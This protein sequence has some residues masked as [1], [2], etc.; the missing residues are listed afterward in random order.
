MLPP[1]TSEPRNNSFYSMIDA[2]LTTEIFGLFAPGRPDI[3]LN[4]AYLP[5]RTVA[6][7]DAQWISEFYVVMHSLAAVV[8]QDLS[9]K[10]QTQWLAEQA[11]YYLPSDSASAAV[12]KSSP[13]SSL[14][15]SSFDYK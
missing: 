10:D 8:N 5:I 9:L 4:L 1:Y 11:S 15:S 6:K 14:N 7:Y 13:S 2:Q 12:Y 3:A